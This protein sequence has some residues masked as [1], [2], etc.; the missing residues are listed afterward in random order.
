MIQQEL[1]KDIKIN[2]QY[3]LK[4]HGHLVAVR[5][6]GRNDAVIHCTDL[7]GK[8]LQLSA[9]DCEIATVICEPESAVISKELI[10]AMYRIANDVF[11]KR[12]TSDVTCGEL[13]HATGFDE[14]CCSVFREKCRKAGIRLMRS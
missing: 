6:T 10:S 11:N 7:D 8:E 1:F 9:K 5:V 14:E 12:I 3:V 4:V 2:G 13:K